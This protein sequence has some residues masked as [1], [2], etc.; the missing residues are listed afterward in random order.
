MP[1]VILKDH[2]GRIVAEEKVPPRGR[3]SDHFVAEMVDHVNGLMTAG[4]PAGPENA[5]IWVNSRQAAV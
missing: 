4:L 5:T 1:Y 3:L 2:Y